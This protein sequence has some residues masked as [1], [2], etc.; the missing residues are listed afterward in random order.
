[1]GKRSFDLFV[2][3]HAALLKVDQEHLARLQAPF[4]NDL[5]LWNRQ[6]ARL[7]R[8]DDQVIIGHAV[9]RRAQAVT[10]Q[11]GTNLATI[12]EHNRR[13]AVPRLKH[14][15]VVFVKR[16]APL[17][18]G[19]VLLPWFGN[20]HH[21]GLTDR[22]TRHRQQLQ[23]VVKGSGVRLVGKADGVK[24]LQIGAK[25]RRRHHTFTCFHPVVVA[26]NG[27]DLAVVRYVAVRVRQRPFRKGVGTKALVH[28]PKGRHAALVLQVKIVGAHLVGQQQAFV[29]H[30]AAGHAGHVIFFTV[31][32]V[33]VLNRSAGCFA[34][35]IQL[36]LQCVLHNHVVAAANKNL[37]KDR[38]LQSH[39]RRH[40]HVTVDRHIPPAKQYLALS[41][42]CSFQRLFAGQA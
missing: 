20:H 9:T 19:G 33:Q 4:S 11:R 10:V 36:A 39:G 12:G 17:V 22:V 38:F 8:H 3:D 18:H 30:R 21:Y 37:L 35:Y 24:L 15:G 27:V 23:A 7:G 28:Q 14:G 32:Q 2:I 13:W 5:V 41:P 1:M 16:F 26:L 34:Y 31:R 42:D 29:N 6:H 25:H 40:R